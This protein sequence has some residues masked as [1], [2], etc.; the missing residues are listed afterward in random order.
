MIPSSPYRSEMRDGGLHHLVEEQYKTEI[1]DR[2]L[3][4]SVGEDD[5]ESLCGELLRN[6]KKRMTLFPAEK[7]RRL[8][9]SLRVTDV[10][11]SNFY[12]LSFPDGVAVVNRS[13]AADA[14]IHPRRYT[15][16]WR[17]E[18]AAGAATAAPHP[19]W[20]WPGPQARAACRSS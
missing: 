15:R 4:A 16:G 17:I 8:K 7:L 9:F 11:E 6:V 1:V 14:D 2:R 5:A 3:R 10:Q 20:H 19:G 13:S 12:N 18:A